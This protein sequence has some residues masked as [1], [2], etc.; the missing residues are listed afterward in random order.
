MAIIT[1]V[2]LASVDNNGSPHHW[3]SPYPAEQAEAEQSS[4]RDPHP[5]HVGTGKPGAALPT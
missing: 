5:G 2:I 3:V 4:D 1:T